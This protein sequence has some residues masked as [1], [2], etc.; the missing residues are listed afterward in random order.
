MP[1]FLADE[2][3]K[4]K[5]KKYK[6]EPGDRM[7]L[8]SKSF[9]NKQ[10]KIG[11]EKVGMKKIRVHDL[12]HSHVSLLIELGFT[13]VAI[14][15]RVGYESIEITFRYAHLFPNKQKRCPKS[16]IPEGRNRYA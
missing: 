2:L 13:P 6:P 15:D 9:L 4:Y 1:D 8:T 10:L 7:F 5:E 12:R 11:A 14:A 3:R 16:F